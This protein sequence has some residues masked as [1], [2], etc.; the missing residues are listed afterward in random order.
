M[1]VTATTVTTPNQALPTIEAFRREIQQIRALF[2]RIIA[3]RDVMMPDSERI[4]LARDFARQGLEIT[5]LII[6]KE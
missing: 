5:A 1:T 2:D 4:A 3:L 6:G